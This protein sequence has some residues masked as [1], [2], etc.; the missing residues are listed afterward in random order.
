MLVL[1]PGLVD[2]HQPVEEP[3][4]ANLVAPAVLTS[5]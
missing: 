4:E 3:P 2:E 1:G 5:N